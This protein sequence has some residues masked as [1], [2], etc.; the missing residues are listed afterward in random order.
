MC[1]VFL[2]GT[3]QESARKKYGL[4][5]EQDVQ[6]EFASAHRCSQLM[7]LFSLEKNE[8]KTGP[9]TFFFSHFESVPTV[10]HVVRHQCVLNEELFMSTLCDQAGQQTA[11]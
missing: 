1:D 11:L 3:V 10:V 2:S 6:K 8:Q 9:L 4:A 7:N 5:D